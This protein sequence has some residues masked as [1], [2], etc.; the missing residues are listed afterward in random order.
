MATEKTTSL[1][2]ALIGALFGALAGL[3][4]NIVMTKWRF[5]R[6][7]WK[8]D[9]KPDRRVGPYARGKV[10]N[11]YIYPI[12]SAYAYITINHED[13]DIID[14][15][16]GLRAYIRRDRLTHVSEDRLCW[17]MAAPVDNPAAIDILP[18][19]H[20]TLHILRI[21]SEGNWIDIA[22]EKGFST[23]R[24]TDI[25][26]IFLKPKKIH[27]LYKD[28]EHGYQGKEIQHTD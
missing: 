3:L 22:S 11:D 9:L 25:S 4:V 26:R 12:H 23:R 14:P 27:R 7:Y 16:S 15:P 19:E 18:G 2:I 6:L 8:L 1:E 28:C 13:D 24:E 21:D 5:W 20:Q 10:V 17:A